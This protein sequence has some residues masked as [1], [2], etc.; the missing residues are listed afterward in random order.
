M[1]DRS[2]KKCL[3]PSQQRMLLMILVMINYWCRDIKLPALMNSNRSFKRNLRKVIGRRIWISRPK[4]IKVLLKFV[5]FAI[6]QY[7]ILIK[8]ITWINV[9]ILT[10]HWILITSYKNKLLWSTQLINM[11]LIWCK[12]NNLILFWCSNFL[13][14]VYKHDYPWRNYSKV[15]DRVYGYWKGI[16]TKNEKTAYHSYYKLVTKES[17]MTRQMIVPIGCPVKLQVVDLPTYDEA[18]IIRAEKS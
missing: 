13:T 9:L 8:M 7:L 14:Y 2:S 16:I 18:N 4:E 11:P 3:K 12:N 10:M 17:S 1:K 6:I 15:L 5:K